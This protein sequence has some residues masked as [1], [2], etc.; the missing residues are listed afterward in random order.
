M[1]AAV[2]A[3]GTDFAQYYV[4]ARLT[5]ERG[6]AAPYDFATFMT[7]LHAVTGQRDVYANSPATTALVMPLSRLPLNAAY[8][9]WNS[10]MVAQFAFACWIAAPGRGWD[11]VARLLASLAAFQVL[12]AIGL[13]QL[14]LAAGGLLVLHWWLLR[15]DR[16]ALAG[17]ALGLAFVKPQ[18]VFL[19]PA[20]LL[21]SGR[22]RAAAVSVAV[23]A[24]LAGACLAALGGDG[25]RQYAQT[26]AFETQYGYA[27]RFTLGTLLAGVLPAAAVAAVPAALCLLVARTQRQEPERLVVA[28]VLASQLATPYLNAADLALLIPCAWLTARASAP[29][30]LVWLA[31][32]VNFTPALQDAVFRFAVVGVE[33]VWLAAL[34]VHPSRP[35]RY[36]RWGR[37]RSASSSRRRSAASL[38]S[39]GR[40]QISRSMP[41]PRSVSI[42]AAPPPAEP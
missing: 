34:A 10:V 1:L 37:M 28:G 23:A 20:A 12:S 9:I 33:L 17:I 36:S 18:N 22:W 41:A 6:W 40:Y 39:A 5:L 2:G 21:V 31:V 35:G 27:G 32:A 7:V 38:P 3:R 25:L 26:V 13:G 15:S 8:A 42:S 30:W 16:E 14:V 19:L 11:R 29:R 24:A 4:A